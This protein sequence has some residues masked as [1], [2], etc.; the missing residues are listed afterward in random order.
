M[1]LNRPDKA[2]D[3]LIRGLEKYDEHYDEAVELEIVDDINLCRS[4]IINALGTTFGITED[5]AYQIMSYDG[6]EYIDALS[7]YSANVIT[8]E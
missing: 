7:Q 5:T 4:N 8:G 3:S 2:L 6:Q 1:K